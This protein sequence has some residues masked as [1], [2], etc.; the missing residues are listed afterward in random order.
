[1][2]ISIR[3]S[4]AQDELTLKPESNELGEPSTC[5]KTCVYT[6]VQKCAKACVRTCVWTGVQTCAET[7]VQACLLTRVSK[8]HRKVVYRKCEGAK[9]KERCVAMSLDMG[10]DM[11]PG[12]FVVMAHPITGRH[13]YRHVYGDVQTCTQTCEYVFRR[14]QACT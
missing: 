14:L 1:M 2:Q 12:M 4:T 8:V 9:N 5:V 11:G 3:L 10:R 7:C 13:L 6:R